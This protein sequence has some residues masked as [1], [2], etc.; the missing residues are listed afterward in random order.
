MEHDPSEGRRYCIGL[1]EHIPPNANREEQE[2]MHHIATSKGSRF[3]L[4]QQSH[5]RQA[6]LNMRSSRRGNYLD[7]TVGDS[8]GS[9]VNE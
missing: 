9:I 7:W 4:G 3:H 1:E 5:R 2:V 6:C 8:M